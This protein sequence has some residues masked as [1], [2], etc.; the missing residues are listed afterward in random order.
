MKETSAQDSNH[1]KI[2]RLIESRFGLI[3]PEVH[4]D[5]IQ[6]AIMERAS[7][8]HINPDDYYTELYSSTE[9]SKLFL[10]LITINETY[11]FREEKHF[12]TLKENVFPEISK[13]TDFVNLWSVTCSTGE[14]AISLAVMAEE[15]LNNRNF[16]VFATDINTD[17]LNVLMTGKYSKNSFRKDGVSYNGLMQKYGKMEGNIWKVDNGILKKIEIIPYNLLQNNIDC[18]PDESIHIA[19]FRN[20]LIY[21]RKE[22][23]T[24]VIK[25]VIKKIAPD[26]FLFLSSAEIPS[27]SFPELNILENNGIYYFQKTGIKEKNKIIDSVFSYKNETELKI[28][29]PAFSAGLNNSIDLD[30]ILELCC[31]YGDYEAIQNNHTKAQLSEDYDRYF[32]LSKLILKT[33]YYINNN[34]LAKAKEFNRSLEKE[35][36]Q[37]HIT[38][39]LFGLIEMHSGNISRAAI[40]F[41][42]SI[43]QNNCF[44]LSHFYLANVLKDTKPQKAFMEYNICKDLIFQKTKNRKQFIKYN[45]LIENFDEMYFYKMCEKWINKLRGTTF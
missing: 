20:T 35:I 43:S 32:E 24:D 29:K 11:F 45:F 40:H 1:Q 39:Y 19:F 22:I 38:Q 42:K 15:F 9:E 6:K 26:G 27:V 8:L 37:N 18:I 36:S 13:K 34:E 17:S 14:E 12:Y 5:I 4:I 33:F 10:N 7:L 30:K 21:M 25:N 28:D 2:L 23:K 44:W 31:Q 3:F 41:E 16:L